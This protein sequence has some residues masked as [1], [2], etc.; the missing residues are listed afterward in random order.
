MLESYLETLPEAVISRLFRSPASCLALLRLLPPLA[1]AIVMR[2]LFTTR[3]VPLH[4]IESFICSRKLRVEALQKLRAL[5][6]VLERFTTSNLEINHTFQRSLQIALTCGPTNESFEEFGESV[7]VSELRSYQNSRWEAML[8]YMVS[9]AQH[10]DAGPSGSQVSLG[11]AAKLSPT[12]ISLLS[13]SGLLSR[14]HRITSEGFQFL[15]QDQQTQV[16][17]LLLH[18]LNNA[19]ELEMDPVDMLNFIFRL[20]TLELGRGHSASQLTQQ[21]Q[22][23][24][25]ELAELGIVMVRNGIFYAAMELTNVS[26]NPGKPSADGSASATPSASA[27]SAISSTGFIIVETNYRLYAYT[28]SPLQISIL[29]LFCS[30]KCRFANLVIG[31]L[32][33]HHARRALTNGISADQIIQYLTANQRGGGALPPTI[34]DQIRLWQLE[35]DRFRQAPGFLFRDFASSKEYSAAMQFAQDVG[36]L[37]WKNDRSR[38]FFV[39]Q[40]SIKDITDYINRL[41]RDEEKKVI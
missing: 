33:R 27:S 20:G 7:P 19:T 40:R 31:R 25:A 18:Y 6:I 12:I 35:L 26:S 41:M 28:D 38:M 13:T 5:K 3:T 37:L 34:I 24:L 14:S 39:E 8:H 10:E 23:I 11:S 1:K 22:R 36:A 29:N 9:S 16:W 30:L 21:Q 4:T 15:L 17:T 2:L 32:T